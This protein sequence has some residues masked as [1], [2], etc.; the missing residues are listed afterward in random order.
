MEL[1]T[2][3]P[4]DQL[5]E[6]YFELRYEV[7]REPLG[8]PPGSEYLSDDAE[9]IH[10]WI[11]DNGRIV[12]VGRVHLLLD[13]E[14]GSAYD[15]KAESTCPGFGPLSGPYTDRM[16]ERGSFIPQ[17]LRPACQFRQMGTHPN[18]RGKGL[19]SQVLSVLENEARKKWDA[20]SGWLQARIEVVPFYRKSNWVCFGNE[21]HVP[22]VG[23]HR[24][25]W[26]S[27]GN[28]SG[29]C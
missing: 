3:Y 11:E 24:S 19:S 25:M 29:Q 21:Y 6:A 5:P 10:A 2:A 23:L 8:A 18:Y 20:K 22:N 27:L 17:K 9:A 28:L 13:S 4:S 26:K 7:L 12:S 14:D 15:E 1:K 16:D